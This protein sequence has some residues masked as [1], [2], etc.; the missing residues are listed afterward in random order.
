M[1]TAVTKPIEVNIVEIPTSTADGDQAT[2]IQTKG[3]NVCPPSW[4][5]PSWVFKGY[6]VFCL[7]ECPIMTDPKQCLVH[8]TN[9]IELEGENRSRRSAKN[10]RG[11]GSKNRNVYLSWRDGAHK[12]VLFCNT[13]ILLQNKLVSFLP[14]LAMQMQ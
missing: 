9:D 8:F 6:G 12:R 4:D 1:G 10:G 13:R 3:P 5:T 7:Y 2:Y 14:T 11:W